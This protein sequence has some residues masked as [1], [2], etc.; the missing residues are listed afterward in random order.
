MKM[1]LFKAALWVTGMLPGLAA[2]QL[3]G[4]PISSFAAG[5]TGLTPFYILGFELGPWQDYLARE[6]TPAYLVEPGM[7]PLHITWMDAEVVMILPAFAEQLMGQPRTRIQIQFEWQ[8][9]DPLRFQGLDEAHVSPGYG[10]ERQLLAPGIIHQLNDN[11]VLGVAAVL[12]YQSYGTSALGMRTISGNVP[13]FMQSHGRGYD[14]Y[15]ENSYGTGVRL[16]LRSEVVEGMAFDAGYQSRIDMEE[17][18]N[19]RGVY[20]HPADLD[21]PARASVGLAFQTNN[22]SWLNFSVERVLYS[23]INAFPSRMLP[24]R[25]LSLLGDS[26]SPNFSWDDLT[27]YSVGWT[28]SNGDDTQWYVDI[29]T[30]SQ[31]LPTSSALSRALNGDLAENAM[32]LG[33]SKRMGDRSRFNFNAAYAPAEYVFGGSVLGVTSDNLDQNFEV[34]AFWTWDF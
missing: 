30:R 1:R 20:S 33:Y 18:A 24:D 9:S 22:Q 17:F 28:W 26:T 23:E 11:Q 34:E 4:L 5:G 29:S 31:P 2:A 3:S 14:P 19:Y 13:N 7:P 27:V 16:A 25:F 8:H 32:M 21:I 15:Q 10:F 6:L 12:A